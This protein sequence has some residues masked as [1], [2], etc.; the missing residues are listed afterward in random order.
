MRPIL[1]PLVGLLF[2]A[3]PARAVDYD[4]IDRKLVKEPAYTQQ[5]PATVLLRAIRGVPQD[6]PKYALLLFGREA[7]VRVWVVLHGDG[8]YLDRNGDGD[9]T[10]ADEHF[11]KV[12]DC[13]GVE[14]A[15][16]DG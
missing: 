6:R 8:L 11:A 4:K 1:L 15:D 9:L 3:A 2:L 5:A 13:K 14:I 16:P 10:G 7:K 12:A